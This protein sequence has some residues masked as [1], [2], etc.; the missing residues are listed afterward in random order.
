MGFIRLANAVR[1]K[2]S[3]GSRRGRRREKGEGMVRLAD[4]NQRLLEWIAGL[5]HLANAILLKVS[6]RRGGG[7]RRGKG[8]EDERGSWN[9][10]RGSSVWLT[11]SCLRLVGKD[12]VGIEEA[13][14]WE[15]GEGGAGAE[16]D[17]EG[18]QSELKTT[19]MDCGFH[20]SGKPLHA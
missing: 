9:G 6:T 7:K 14:R 8:K 12:Q 5:I 11:L 17:R 16:R 4:Q 10:F 3:R 2:V 13:R 15:V 19:G 18:S 1:L 20:L